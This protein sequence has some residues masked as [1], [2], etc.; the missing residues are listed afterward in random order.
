[1]G[2]HLEPVDPDNHDMQTPVYTVVDRLGLKIKRGRAPIQTLVI[3]QID[4]PT[5]D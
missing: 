3:D 1:M 5:M 4:H 2:Y